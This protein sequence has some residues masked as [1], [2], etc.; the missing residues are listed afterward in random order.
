MDTPQGRRQ[1]GR[2]P[3]R[4]RLRVSLPTGEALIDANVL[5]ISL[6]GVRLI[7]S[8]PLSEG[9][10]VLLTFQIKRRKGAQTEEV[11]SRVIHARMDDDAWVVGLKFNQALDP[12]RTPLLAKA[13]TS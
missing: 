7:C 4:V 9:V 5:D 10:D 1:F 13:A 2:P 6:D 3:F 11:A 8:E 12:Q